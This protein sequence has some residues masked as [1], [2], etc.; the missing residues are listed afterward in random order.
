MAG[1]G[2]GRGCGADSYRNPPLPP[3]S[4]EEDEGVAQSS[5]APCPAA[6][7][8]HTRADNSRA[9]GILPHRNPLDSG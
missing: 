5:S 6:R 2:N 8:I 9:H 3:R 1:G 7:S 4:M